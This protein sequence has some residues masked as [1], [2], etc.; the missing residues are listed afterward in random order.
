MGVGA[1]C[2]GGWEQV[3]AQR[4]LMPHGTACHAQVV[5]FS[6]W[7]QE[8]RLTLAAWQ[9]RLLVAAAALPGPLLSYVPT[10][11]LDCVLDTLTSVRQQ[12][13]EA[14]AGHALPPAAVAPS[15]AQLKA[16][17]GQGGVHSGGQWS[18]GNMRLEGRHWEGD[19]GGMPL[20]SGRGEVCLPRCMHGNN[21]MNVRGA[22]SRRPAQ[23]PWP[24]TH[25]VTTPRPAYTLH[26]LA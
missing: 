15:V 18:Q 17:V 4:I 23:A 11:Y 9:S 6:G 21:G 1:V 2:V 10:C 22:A 3:L 8:A 26:P 14:A 7:K 25:R 12:A 19:L 24:M 16:Q 5:F 20:L 13:G